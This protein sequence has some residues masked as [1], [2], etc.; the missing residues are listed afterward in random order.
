[1]QYISLPLSFSLGETT[2]NQQEF[3]NDAVMYE[4]AAG[5]NSLTTTNKGR[6]T[7][8]YFLVTCQN[9]Y[10]WNSSQ[11]KNF[12]LLLLVDFIYIGWLFH[13]FDIDPDFL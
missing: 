4:K 12:E 8:L 7:E 2:A 10:I 3:A 11:P 1:M 9:E 13:P 6:E 5:C